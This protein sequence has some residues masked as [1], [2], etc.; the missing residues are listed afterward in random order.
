M[1]L[2]LLTGAIVAFAVGALH[3]WLG[4][5]YIIIR[6][7]RRED[8]PRLFGS[9][10]FTRRTIR[11]AWHLTTIAWWGLGAQLLWLSKLPALDPP[12]RTVVVVIGWTFLVSGL[13]SLIWSRGRHLSWVLFLAISVAA[14]LGL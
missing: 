13:V 9:D 3:S 5:R 10:L 11:F 1:N 8:L 4:E 14:W 2:Y 7:L 12:S 6:L